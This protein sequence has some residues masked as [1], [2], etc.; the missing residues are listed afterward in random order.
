M[1]LASS[2]E[3][4]KKRAER[5]AKEKKEERRRQQIS[6]PS[7]ID[8]STSVNEAKVQRRLSARRN[9]SNKLN[10]QTKENARPNQP[11]KSPGPTPYWQVSRE[12]RDSDLDFHPH[13]V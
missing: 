5:V 7:T 13:H 3:A 10:V 11:P 6:L 12:T 9:S 4:S 8:S 2:R 1:P